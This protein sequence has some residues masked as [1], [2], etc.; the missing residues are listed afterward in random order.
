MARHWQDRDGAVDF[1]QPLPPVMTTVIKDS[2][3]P[4]DRINSSSALFEQVKLMLGPSERQ[5]WP[6]TT[7]KQR[8]CYVEAKASSEDRNRGGGKVKCFPPALLDAKVNRNS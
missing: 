3:K 6:A 2:L 7:P 1:V 4:A 8:T 5:L